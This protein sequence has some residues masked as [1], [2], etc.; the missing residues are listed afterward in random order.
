MPPFF[1]RKRITEN[2]KWQFLH[3]IELEKTKRV[4]PIFI[5]YKERITM[6]KKTQ[7]SNC[8]ILYCLYVEC[9]LG[10]MWLSNGIGS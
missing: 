2:S 10:R 8:I 3:V 7:K 4:C 6:R 1:L 9:T 5:F